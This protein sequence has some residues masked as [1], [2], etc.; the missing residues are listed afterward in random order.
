MRNTSASLRYAC[1]GPYNMSGEPPKVRAVPHGH[2]HHAF[3]DQ[4][5]L[6]L[7]AHFASECDAPRPR[8][9]PDSPLQ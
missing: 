7:Y 2:L 5:V 4:P 3:S 8:R 1:G 9:R 6:V